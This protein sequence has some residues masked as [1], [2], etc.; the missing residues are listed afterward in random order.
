MEHA[1]LALLKMSD[2]KPEARLGLPFSSLLKNLPQGE[3]KQS[4]LREVCIVVSLVILPYCIINFLQG[5]YL[6]AFINLLFLIYLSGNAWLLHTQKRDKLD[7]EILLFAGAIYIFFSIERIGPVAVY[8]AYIGCVASFLL[9]ELRRAVWYNTIFIILLSALL[10]FWFELSVALR[11]FGTLA[12][13]A[14]MTYILTSRLERRNQQLQV[15]TQQLEKANMAKSEF[16]ANM[17]H[18]MRTPLTAVAGYSESLL[19]DSSLG[20]KGQEQLEAIVLNARHLASLINDVLDLSKIEAGYLSTTVQKVDLAPLV[21]NLVLTQE[22]AARK[23]GLDFVLT[24]NMPLPRHIHIDPM[25]LNQIFLNLFGNA[26]KFTSTG[27]VGLTIEY[28]TETRRLMFRVIDSGIG[29]PAESRAQLFQQFSQVDSSIIRDY[30]GSGLGL[31][32]SQHLAELMNGHIEHF[33]LDPGSMFQLS[34]RL[35]STPEEWIDDERSL[36]E[37]H[38]LNLQPH[39][40][41]AGHVLIAEDSSVNQLLIS[42]LV[43]KCGPQISVVSNGL[44]AVKFARDNQ[45]D[46]ILM[47]L[48]MP[49]MSGM[50]AADQIKEFDPQIPIISLS[51]DVLRYE[52]DSDEMASFTD[53]LAKPVD[54]ELLHT[55]LA[56][57]LP[58]V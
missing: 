6:L 46:L 21:A 8:A 22:E 52:I 19:D 25:R 45:I 13:V 14:T 29:I 36:R 41:L 7:T 34:L 54:T 55:T 32:I 5:A 2:K 44:E 3:Q 49:V 17:S 28:D 20:P 53:G 23:E 33:P 42:L 24:V 35:A 9:L 15:R 43:E 11:A 37:V 56:R 31:Y 38:H 12:L 51:A 26:I 27:F 39:A 4:V 58:T 10:F 30:G 18:E 50:E 1:C 16:L 47:D 40:K 57:F 48:Q